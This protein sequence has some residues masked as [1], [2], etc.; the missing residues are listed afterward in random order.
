MQAQLNHLHINDNSRPLI[1][2]GSNDAMYEYA[3]VCESYGIKVHGVI[4]QDYYG[5]TDTRCD[6]PVIDAESAF[7]D[8]EKL[9]YYRGN[10]NF[11]CANNWLPMKVPSI[12]RNREKRNKLLTLIDTHNLNCISLTH[13]MADISKSA[14]IGRGVYIDAFV[15]IEPKIVCHDYVNIYSHAAIG[16][17]TIIGRNCVFQRRVSVSSNC[18]FGENVFFGLA[19]KQFRMNVKFGSNTFIHEGVCIKRGTEEN[20][21]VAL[22]SNNQRRIYEL[23]ESTE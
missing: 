21:I 17:D 18:V 19:V 14:V 9:A 6:I 12:V 16:H 11:F 20:E 7:D 3:E 23:Q 8:P 15:S 13:K 10:F 5:N 4:D 1:F 22:G 2:L